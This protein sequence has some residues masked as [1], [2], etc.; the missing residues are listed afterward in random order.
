MEQHMGFGRARGIYINP[1][2]APKKKKKQGYEG[3]PEQTITPVYGNWWCQVLN[4]RYRK[5]S[6]LRLVI[7]LHCCSVKS[8][9]VNPPRCCLTAGSEESV[10]CET[11]EVKVD[12]AGTS[13][14]GLVQGSAGRAS[15]PVFYVIYVFNVIYVPLYLLFLVLT[16]VSFLL[17]LWCMNT[18]ADCRIGTWLLRTPYGVF[19]TYVNM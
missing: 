10:T 12:V 4:R 19:T 13:G 16:F 17:L 18:C 7:R 9:R 11:V 2:R 8:T 1:E 5:W 15:E 3:D 6:S 14:L